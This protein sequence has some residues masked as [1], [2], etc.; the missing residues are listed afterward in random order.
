MS[1]LIQIENYKIDIPNLMTTYQVNENIIFH[2]M[3]NCLI[4][5]KYD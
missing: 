2:T 4:S 5:F 3:D 1:K